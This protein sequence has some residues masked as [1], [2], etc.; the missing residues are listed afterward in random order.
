VCSAYIA[1]LWGVLEGFKI[2]RDC[3]YNHIELNIDS[4]V[5]VSNIRA[6]KGGHQLVGI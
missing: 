1:E 4:L 5:I 6:K 3:G 2:T